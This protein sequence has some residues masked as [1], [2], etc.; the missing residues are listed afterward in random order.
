MFHK[1]NTNSFENLKF[2]CVNAGSIRS[3]RERRSDEGTTMGGCRC[4]ERAIAGQSW[5]LMPES[6]H[7]GNFQYHESH[8]F[9]PDQY[10]E[11]I[12]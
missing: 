6:R 2:C 7:P 5:V 3:F 1:I 11:L 4:E 10:L 12:G 8:R 9:I